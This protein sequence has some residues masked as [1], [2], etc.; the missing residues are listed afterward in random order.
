MIPDVY[1]F[2]GTDGSW[3]SGERRFEQYNEVNLEHFLSIQSHHTAC[4]DVSLMEDSV[5]LFLEESDSLQVSL[6]LA[7]S[8]EQ[9][10]SSRGSKF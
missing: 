10:I 2:E 1:D 6:S 3:Q 7:Y 9:L 5:R 4:Q 8:L